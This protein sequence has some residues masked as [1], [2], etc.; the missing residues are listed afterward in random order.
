MRILFCSLASHGLL[1]PGIGLA[2]TLRERGH[3]VAFVTGLAFS[4]LLEQVGFERIARGDRDGPS[5]EIEQW[6]VPLAAAIQVKHIEYA[7]ARFQPDVLVGQALALGPLIVAER[8]QIPIASLGLFTY[9]WPRRRSEPPP[10]SIAEGRLSWRYDDMMQRYNTLRQLF[11][12][13]PNDAPPETTPL[14]ADAFLLQSVPSLVEEP[15]RL[16]PRA[17]L[18]GPGLWEP[19]H[20]DPELIDWL[21]TARAAGA[22]ILYVQHG[23]F[24]NAP[25]CWPDLVAACGRQGIRIVAALGRMNAPT[26]AISEHVFV[27]AHL[28]QGLALPYAQA[29]VANGNTTAV[30]GALTHGLPSLLIPDGGEQ[31]DVAEQCLRLGVAHVLTQTAITDGTIERALSA[32]LEQADLRRQARRV[33]RTLRDEAPGDRGAHVI[34][35]LADTRQPVLRSEV[36]R[37][38]AA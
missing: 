4:E 23:R 7:I 15:Q 10:R 38:C 2:H 21:N 30:L 20:H 12:L 17:H 32:V 34:E 16:P 25:A 29:V 24:F 3:T 27:R 6:G 9:L 31:P 22:P 14:L 35:R 13:A 37:A 11:R 26:D 33:Q 8:Q 28:P 36:A 18:V 1:Y 5:F 19:P